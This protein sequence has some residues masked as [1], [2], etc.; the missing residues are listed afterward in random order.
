MYR[1]KQQEKAESNQFFTHCRYFAKGEN[2][3]HLLV[4][5]ARS[6]S[7]TNHIASITTASG[8]VTQNPWEILGAFQ[9]FYS[10]LY[11][12]KVQYAMQQLHGF[13]DP[14]ELPCLGND[15]LLSHYDRRA[16]VSKGCG[17]GP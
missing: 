10:D 15:T 12:S 9:Y 3:G 4:V 8:V 14:L 16:T 6:Q 5:I 7:P 2:T 1:Q 13:L 17:R 11:D